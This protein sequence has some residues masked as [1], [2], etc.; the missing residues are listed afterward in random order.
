MNDIKTENCKRKE[1]DNNEKKIDN[2][3]TTKMNISNVK[4]A[5]MT[6]LKSFKYV[7]MFIYKTFNNVLWRNVI[8]DFDCNNSFIY[9][10]NEFVNEITF[11]YKMINTSNDFM[12]IEEYK[13][14]LVINRF[15]EKNQRMF[16][17]NIVYVLFIDVILVFVTRLKNKT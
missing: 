6:N 10:L 11:A 12:L 1:K 9:D 2:E 3:K 14:M 7:N 15:N 5:N 4:F 13:I 8:Y 17:N 16:F